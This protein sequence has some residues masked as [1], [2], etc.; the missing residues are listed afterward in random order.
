MSNIHIQVG[1]FAVV[2]KAEYNGPQVNNED[3]DNEATELGEDLAK[4]LGGNFIYI[5]EDDDES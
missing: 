1:N 5:S 4:L 3:F 2:I